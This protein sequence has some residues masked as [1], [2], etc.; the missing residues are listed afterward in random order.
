MTSNIKR[1]TIDIERFRITTEK[2]FT[3]TLFFII[4][5]NMNFK[6]PQ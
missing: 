2:T 4:R 5:K 3:A 6:E 1:T